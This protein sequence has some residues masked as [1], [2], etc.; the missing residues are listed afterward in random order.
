M[1]PSFA[2]AKLL[3]YQNIT[4]LTSLNDALPNGLN[5]FNACIPNA[6]VSDKMA[7][8]IPIVSEDVSTKK[9]HYHLKQHVIFWLGLNNDDPYIFTPEPTIKHS[10][11]ADYL[12]TTQSGPYLNIPPNVSK[13][14]VIAIRRGLNCDNNEKILDVTITRFKRG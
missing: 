3:D 13:F 6:I 2:F 1:N 14:D 9:H 7:T 8:S 5:A 12:R 11:V 10:R 4:N